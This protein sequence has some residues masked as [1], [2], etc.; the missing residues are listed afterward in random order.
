LV[1]HF[2]YNAAWQLVECRCSPA[3]VSNP[4]DLGTTPIYQYVW[5]ARYVDAPVLRDKNTDGAGGDD[6]CN[7]GPLHYLTDLPRRLVRREVGRQART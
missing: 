4:T 6:E 2:Y 3:V 1:K 5:S 7:D